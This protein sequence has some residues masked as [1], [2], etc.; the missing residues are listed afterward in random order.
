MDK[1]PLWTVDWG[2]QWISHCGHLW[3]WPRAS[4]PDVWCGQYRTVQENGTVQYS[5]RGDTT[6]Q[7]RIVQKVILQNRIVDQVILQNSAE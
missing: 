7:C 5:R 3:I 4:K 1:S 6:E 2:H